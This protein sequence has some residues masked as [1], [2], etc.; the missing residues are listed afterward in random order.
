M[1]YV[2]AQQNAQT[3]FKTALRTPVLT[4]QCVLCVCVGGVVWRDVA[5]CVWCGSAGKRFV[6]SGGP[7]A[8]RWKCCW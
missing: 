1:H 3:Y 4:G 7:F 5:W 8:K 6:L 2:K